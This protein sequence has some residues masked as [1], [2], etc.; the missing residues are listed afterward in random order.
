MKRKP[1]TRDRRAPGPMAARP[2]LAALAAL[3]AALCATGC[4]SMPTGGPVQSY[5]VTQGTDA[6][7]QPY[8][9]SQPQP[10][11]AGWNPSQIVQGFLIASASFGDYSRV[12]RQYLTPKEQASWNTNWSAV[13]Y[14]SGPNVTPPTYP[15]TAK[16][17]TTATVQVTGTIQASLMGS[18]SY[19][20]PSSSSEGGLSYAP[21]PFQLQK[22]PGG[23]WRISYA[24]PEL[25]LT[26]NSFAN[27]YQLRNL[28]F[29][30]P[31]SRYLVP[32]PVY[33][34]LG[35]KA[36]DLMNQLVRDLIT[37]PGDWLAGGATRTAFP[38][39]T[40]VTGVGFS[41]VTAVVS[42]TGTIA[43]AGGL[44]LRQVSEQ[45]LSTLSGAVQ[46]GPNGQAVKSV[47]VLLNGKP[48]I[49][50]DN[51]GSPVQATHH[52]APAS[53][54]STKFYY[55]D[56]SGYLISRSTADSASHKIA[57]IGTGYRQIAVSP[58]GQYVAALRG[59][60]LYAG[61]VGRPLVARGS[62]YVAISWDVND[63]LWAS[64]GT[65][66]VMF[67]DSARTRRPLGQVVP[68]TVV[69]AI[70]PPFTQL[71]VAPDGVRVAIVQDGDILTF[72][73]IS[74]Q[75]GP[76]PRISLSTVQENPP[77]SDQ[78][79]AASVTFTSIAWYGPDNVITLATGPAVTE[80]PISG[81]A[82]TSIPADA[83]ME[84]I[85]A[86]SGQ[87]LIAGLPKGQVATN[88]SL[89]GSWVPLGGTENVPTYPG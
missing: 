35:A 60:T 55:V 8:V 6:Q 53:G 45:L 2:V 66:I 63:N 42:L 10:P 16:N 87:P 36:G 9:Q 50:P 83:G 82:S 70:T 75:Q 31:M 40:K 15:S 80:Y 84:T 14:K 67:R 88:A 43:K 23:Q 21:A 65:R 64:A 33:V 81:G 89:T 58:D 32:D 48:W 86:S 27:D 51:Q 74:G 19:S 46:G 22:M 37:P 28:Y 85:A 68:V 79:Q 3:L 25:L 30:D 18:G 56:N 72:G 54:A 12:A 62:G 77:V 1:V 73:A 17:S 71:K 29:F 47:E 52:Y 38:A 69:N 4:V 26:S 78:S 39:G 13:V 76:D 24:P 41:G 59:T 34:P 44:T 20:V 61:P 57:E 11:G 5:P 49:P 7:N